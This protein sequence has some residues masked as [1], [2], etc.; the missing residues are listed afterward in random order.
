MDEI[1]FVFSNIGSVNSKNSRGGLLRVT[2]NN[3]LVFPI[4]V[5]GRTLMS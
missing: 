1:N 5:E 2:I 3:Y 4:A